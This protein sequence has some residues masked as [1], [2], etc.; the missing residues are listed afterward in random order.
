[1]YEVSKCALQEAQRTLERAFA[2]F[3]CGPCGVP[4][5]TRLQGKLSVCRVVLASQWEPS[6]RTCSGCGWVDADLTL[7]DRTCHCQGCDAC[8]LL[9]DHDLHAASNLATLAT[10]ATLAGSSSARQNSGGGEGAGQVHAA[11]LQLSSMK[12]GPNTV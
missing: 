6:S 8:D 5:P 1:M 11:L 7:A 2:H 3:F 4:A 12:Q 10:P 9:L